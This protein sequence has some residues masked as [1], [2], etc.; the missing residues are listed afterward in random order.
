MPQPIMQMIESHSRHADGKT[1]DIFR[2]AVIA[3]R[4]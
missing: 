1:S 3:G 4:A 2:K